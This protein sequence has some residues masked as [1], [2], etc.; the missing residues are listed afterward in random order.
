VARRFAGLYAAVSIA[1][2]VA[3]TR[4]A[5]AQP[6]APPGYDI[7]SRSDGGLEIH[8]HNMPLKAVHADDSQNALALDFQNPIDGAAFEHLSAD[9]PDWISMAYASY[10]TGV[11]RAPR[12]VTFLTRNE[13]DGFSLRIVPRGPVPAPAPNPA[14]LRGEVDG[15]PP[16]MQAGYPP[17]PPPGGHYDAYNAIRNYDSLEL[18]LHRGDPLWAKAYQR[19][20][21]QGDSEADFGSEYH[22]YHNGD[23]V[24]AS[25]GH[26]KVSLGGGLSLIGSLYDTDVAANQVR[27][28]DGSF[29][30]NVKSNVI[31]GAGGFAFDAW[32]DTEASLEAMQQNNITGGRIKLYTGDPDGWWQANVTYHQA[33]MDTPEAVLN[34]GDKDEVVLATGQRLGWGLW[35]SLAG[36]MDNYGVH[37]DSRAVRTAGWDGNLRWSTDLGGLLAG[38]S[39]DGHGEYV[40]DHASF[41][42]DAP[43]PYI[44]LSIRNMETHAVTASLSSLVWGD[45]LWFDLYGGYVTDRYASD[46]ALYGLG[47]RY[48]PEEGV[49]LALGVRHSAVSFTQ[50]E[51]GA[52]TSAGL[53]FTLGFNGPPLNGYF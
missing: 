33:D 43:S 34:R 3:V 21:Q 26:D 7:V 41:T 27:A 32:D 15:P 6:M 45:V 4:A 53:S 49:D 23:R 48:H 11:I 19:A 25:Q 14:G 44:P 42:G 29:S 28:Q 20:A 24:I 8:F 10:D 36:R 2:L 46:G 17:P 50:G 47:L 52:E 13:T 37:A 35:A 38:L 30:T 16:P 9:F 5:P 1:V 40:W 22:A 51:T 12:P 31:G 18:A 39:Y